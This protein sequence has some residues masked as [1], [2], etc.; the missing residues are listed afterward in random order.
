MTEK[1]NDKEIVFSFELGLIT[2]V[3]SI[4]FYNLGI[5]NYYTNNNTMCLVEKRRWHIVRKQLLAID[6]QILFRHT[7]TC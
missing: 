5:C 2:V 4:N 1:S 3:W 7:N 6:N